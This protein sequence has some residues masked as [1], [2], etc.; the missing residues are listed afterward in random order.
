VAIA[1]TY[2]VLTGDTLFGIARAFHTSVQALRA[3]NGAAVDVIL[4]HQQVL[5]PAGS[6]PLLASEVE[7]TEYRVVSGDTILDIAKRFFVTP[8]ELLTVNGKLQSADTLFTGQTLVIP[9]FG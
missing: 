4:D 9:V 5:L 6:H 8:A 1:G 2:T 3:V 7:T